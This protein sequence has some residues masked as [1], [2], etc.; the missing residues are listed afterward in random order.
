LVD[1]SNG[2]Q[3]R[4]GECSGLGRRQKKGKQLGSDVWG[5]RSKCIF[6]LMTFAFQHTQEV[7]GG[8]GVR[9]AFVDHF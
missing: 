9:F 8:G 7:V 1:G 5:G 2:Q 3:F 6:K 4:G